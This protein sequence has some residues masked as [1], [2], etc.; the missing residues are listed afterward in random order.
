MD[1]I[2]G[3]SMGYR[4]VS[5]TNLRIE[6]KAII[7]DNPFLHS[8]VQYVT[9]IV[10]ADTKIPLTPTFSSLLYDEETGVFLIKDEINLP[11]QLVHIYLSL[12]K[13]L[14][15]IGEC[16]YND[17]FDDIDFISGL[18]N[19]ENDFAPYEYYKSGIFCKIYDDKKRRNQEHEKLQEKL[20][21]KYLE[22]KNEEWYNEG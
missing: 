21:L 16:I 12:D 15:I 11:N 1:G 18:G 22:S 13:K 20:I 7:V 10:D 5:G 3:K 17:Y 14:R 2:N 9:H 4:L 8:S 6:S 19:S